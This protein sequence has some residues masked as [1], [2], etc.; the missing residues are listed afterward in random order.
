MG[1]DFK[2]GCRVAGSWF[3]CKR[4]EGILIDAINMDEQQAKDMTKEE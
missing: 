4:H 3:L 2:C 1:Q